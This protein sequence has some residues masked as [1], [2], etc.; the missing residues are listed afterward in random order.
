MAALL[1]AASLGA[2]WAMGLNG[3]TAWGWVAADTATPMAQAWRWWTAALVHV[4]S[5]HLQANLWAAL[6]VAAWGWVARAG[7]AQALA[8]LL[9][10]PLSQALLVTD[11][12]SLSRYAGLSA[13]LHA[14]AAIVCWQLLWHARGARR[15]V[16]A[17]VAA[18]IALKLFLEVPVLQ[19]LWS[20]TPAADQALA[21][22]PDAPGHVLAGHAHGCG[23]WAGVMAAALV[24]GIMAWSTRRHRPT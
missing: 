23:V 18:A 2:W 24:D 1:A 20:A 16:G 3:A 17:A 11:P 4:N 7:T 14:G 21:P 12:G 9:A 5:A 8:W 15:A 19:A 10:W 6:V 13:T 22:L